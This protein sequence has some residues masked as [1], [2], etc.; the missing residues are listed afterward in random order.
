MRATLIYTN[1]KINKSLMGDSAIA[2]CLLLLKNVKV[3]KHIYEQVIL[4]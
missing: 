2:S 1:F 3:L 4:S